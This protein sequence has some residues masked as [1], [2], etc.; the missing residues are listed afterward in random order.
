[1]NSLIE[2]GDYIK[3]IFELYK[4]ELEKVKKIP[5]SMELEHEHYDAALDRALH[6]WGIFES[7][8]GLC[9]EPCTREMAGVNEALN[10]KINE[11]EK[12]KEKLNRMLNKS[13]TNGGSLVK[14]EEV[15]EA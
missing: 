13:M 7:S 4:V 9:S 12:E 5:S 1:M 3:F 8:L 2:R 6:E 15:N 11:L 10:Q 14:A